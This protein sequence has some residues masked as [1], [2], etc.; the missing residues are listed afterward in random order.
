MFKGSVAVNG[1][2]LTVAEI[3]PQSFAAFVIPH[4][5]RKTNL[6]SIVPGDQ[7]NI[8]FDLMAKYIERMLAPYAP[9]D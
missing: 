6:Q 8:E 5:R 4:T 7:V 9:Q 2:S 3:L 1:I